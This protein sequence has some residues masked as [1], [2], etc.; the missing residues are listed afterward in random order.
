MTILVN[1]LPL[2][3]VELKKRGIP[4]REAFRQIDRYQKESFWADSGLFE[5]IQIFVISNGTQTKYY[6]NTTRFSHVKEQKSRRRSN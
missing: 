3:H 5:Y 4:L 2:V 6:S 1:G